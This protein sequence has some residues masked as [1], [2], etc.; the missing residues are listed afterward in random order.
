MQFTLENVEMHN[1]GRNMSETWLSLDNRLGDYL[2][3]QNVIAERSCW[4]TILFNII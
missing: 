2:L 3:C 4:Y 1:E